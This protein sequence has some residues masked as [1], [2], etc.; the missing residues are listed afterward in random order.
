MRANHRRRQMAEENVCFSVFYLLK[1][2]SSPPPFT[3]F[4][5]STFIPIALLLSWMG[6][7]I[8]NLAVSFTPFSQYF[9]SPALLISSHTHTHSSHIL[10][11][12]FAIAD[13]TATAD[14]ESCCII[15]CRNSAMAA[16]TRNCP[17]DV[18]GG[19]QQSNRY[20]NEEDNEANKKGMK[21]WMKK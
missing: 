8:K 11:P 3:L 1:A 17:N 15:K 6:A 9:L 12:Q 10:L 4:Q 2:S 13:E 14:G 20:A 21:E 16:A 18:N 5:F 19:N 7:F